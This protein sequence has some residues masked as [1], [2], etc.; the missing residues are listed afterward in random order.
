MVNAT[1]DEVPQQRRLLT[2][3]P[4]PRSRELAARRDRAIPK[5]VSTTL[6]IFVVRAGPGMLEDVDGNRLIDSARASRRP[7]R[8]TALP[9]W[10]TPSGSRPPSSPTPAS[11]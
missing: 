11:R 2:E 1:A 5:G 7:T 10:S 9:W 6:P 3:I 8:A 4:G